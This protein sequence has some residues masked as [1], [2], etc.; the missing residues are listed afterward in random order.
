[1]NNNVYINI[2]L[3]CKLLIYVMFNASY[4]LTFSSQF[5]TVYK[6]T[7]MVLLIIS[8]FIIEISY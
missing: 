3:L 4:L 7:I 1:M 5:V 6:N 2:I 8:L